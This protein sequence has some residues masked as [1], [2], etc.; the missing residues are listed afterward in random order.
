MKIDFFPLENRKRAED[1]CVFK[2]ISFAMYDSFL[3]VAKKC[4]RP[5]IIKID[6]GAVFSIPHMNTIGA[7]IL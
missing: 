7:E 5:I 3:D 2:D 4:S 6:W 1:D